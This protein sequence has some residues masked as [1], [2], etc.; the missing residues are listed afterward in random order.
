MQELGQVWPSF[1]SVESE[2]SIH[3]LKV[4][5]YKMDLSHMKRKCQKDSERDIPVVPNERNR[6]NHLWKK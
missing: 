4:Y 6:W 1:K 2:T 3:V 5:A